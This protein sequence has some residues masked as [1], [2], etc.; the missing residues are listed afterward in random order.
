[1]N[2]DDVE[3]SEGSTFRVADDESVEMGV[4]ESFESRRLATIGMAAGASASYLQSS[5][6]LNVNLPISLSVSGELIP[7]F[8]VRNRV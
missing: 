7:N 4:W 3:A 6:W 1:M 5:R 2:G 8:R